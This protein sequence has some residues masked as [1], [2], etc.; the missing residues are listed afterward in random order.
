[1]KCPQ[2]PDFPL[3]SACALFETGQMPARKFFSGC[4]DSW[5]NGQHDHI[6]PKEQTGAAG[7]AR[8]AGERKTV[9][10]RTVHKVGKM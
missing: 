4:S 10:K 5:Q 2:H 6:I 7:K 8:N 3:K 9:R 1:M